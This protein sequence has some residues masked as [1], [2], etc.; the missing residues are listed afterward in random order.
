MSA[1]AHPTSN[2]LLVALQEPDQAISTLEHVDEC[3]ACRVRLSRIQQTSNLAPV[4]T[5]SLQRIVQASAPLPAV[6]ADIVSGSQ[7]E[8]PQPDEVWRVGRSEALLVWIRQVFDDGVADAIPLVLDVE[9][10]DQE[11]VIVDADATPLATETAAMVALRTHIH[12][13]A[14]LNRVGSLDI[15]KAVTEVM[16][17]AREGRRPSGV[18]VGPPIDDDDDQRLEYRQALRDLLAELSP[19]AWSDTDDEPNSETKPTTN[20]PTTNR[21]SDG[22]EAIESRLS[23]QLPDLQFHDVAQQ[24]IRIDDTIEV[25]T[26][27]KVVYLG[28]PVLVVT[29]HGEHATKLPEV[30]RI[31]AACQI[32]ASGEPDVDAVAI[33]IPHSDWSTLL[34][35]TAHMRDAFELPS[36]ARKGPTAT[37]V[38]L[39]LA[40]TLWKYLEGEAVPWE[41]TDPVSSRLGTD[42]LHQMAVRHARN[43]IE[44]IHAA[45]KRAH[46]T[47]KK[48]TWENLPDEFSDQVARFITAIANETTIEDAL[49]ELRLETPD[50]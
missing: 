6:L 37:L 16:T 24:T 7:D 13:G 47:A 14:F 11:S 5:D 26:R 39:G 27:R 23:E 20:E 40:D 34:I 29:L 4:R 19:S 43:S 48:N 33:A 22:I 8:A 25:T 35:T 50:D 2:D 15:R 18:R 42:D 28:S 46:Q 9:L 38:G 49:A 30:G 21:S 32:M 12:L 17:A 3:L 36:G 44:Q 1:N 41:V 10:A 31:V 45:G